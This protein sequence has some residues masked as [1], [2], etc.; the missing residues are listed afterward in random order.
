MEWIDSSQHGYLAKAGQT[1]AQ[2]SVNRYSISVRAD[3]ATISIKCYVQQNNFNR[4]WLWADGI[5]V[6]S[7]RKYLGRSLQCL[8]LLFFVGRTIKVWADNFSS[9]FLA[10]FNLLLFAFACCGLTD[11]SIQIVAAFQILSG[12][13]FATSLARA[14]NKRV[15]CQAGWTLVFPSFSFSIRHLLW[16]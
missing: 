14:G 15:W 12:L 7:L 10:F 9:A 4:H 1:E 13:H 6:P 5:L 11:Y 2:S 8:F 16:A 3:T